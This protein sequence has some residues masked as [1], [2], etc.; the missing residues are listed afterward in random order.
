SPNSPLYI[1]ISER[2]RKDIQS[3]QFNIGDRL[4]A[5]AQLSERFGVNR[6]T[7]RQA[8]AQLRQD[9][10]LRVERGKGT[11]VTAAPIRYAIGRKVRYN[12]MLKTQGHTV[13][14]EIVRSL[15]IPA[16]AAIAKG[17]SIEIG[18]PIALLER[19]SFADEVPI[20]ISTG[21]FPLSLFPDLRSPDSLEQLNNANSISKWLSD[22]YSVDHL[23]HQT[24]VSARLVRP[25]DAKRLA[26]SLGQPI[27]LAES[28]N[29]DQHGRT[30]EY[31]VTRFRGDRM[32]MVFEN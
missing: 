22:R 2:L 8:I 4:P 10:T 30:I 1:Q 17:L 14:F 13:R 26:L 9:G 32:E 28:I 11:F 16:D 7:L 12:Q 18:S 15:E 23:R 3:G 19:V 21:H 6:H 24:S 20:S 29:V 5:E 27:L 31:G 25:E